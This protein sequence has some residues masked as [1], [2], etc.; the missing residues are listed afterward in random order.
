ML[1]NAFRRRRLGQL[2]SGQGL[3]HGQRLGRGGRRRVGFCRGFGDEALLKL[4]LTYR[5]R[6][7]LIECRR[8]CRR[9]AAQMLLTEHDQRLDRLLE[10]V[11]DLGRQLCGILGDDGKQGVN[12]AAYTLDTFLAL[13]YG[14]HGGV[15]E[16]LLDGPQRFD[17]T[18]VVK[19]SPQL[20]L[21]V[22]QQRAR[23][24][25]TELRRPHCRA[26]IARRRVHEIINVHASVLQAFGISGERTDA[27][28]ER[29]EHG[30]RRWQLAQAQIVNMRA[31]YI[32]QLQCALLA[33]HLQ[34]TLDLRHMHG[35][36]VQTRK[37]R[38]VRGKFLHG[39]LDF[40]K[41]RVYFTGDDTNEFI[42]LGFAHVGDFNALKLRDI[43]DI[44][45]QQSL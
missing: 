41:R 44:T 17:I 26:H 38:G 4:A 15:V 40:A 9:A 36:F 7:R 43:S 25:L 32:G 28:G 34:R 16:S 1:L 29:V 14:E 35:D 2:D 6:C 3:G 23:V 33:Q 5:H 11:A 21:H 30:L 45:R 27:H 12:L 13:A 8:L 39:F 19:P 22:V 10:R 18:P 20:R 37:L 42:E 24:H 31:D